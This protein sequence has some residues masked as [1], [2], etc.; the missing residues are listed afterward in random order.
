MENKNFSYSKNFFEIPN[1]EI[2]Y[3][4]GKLTKYCLIIPV[5]NEGKRIRRLIDKIN[6]KEISKLIDIVI[7]DGGSSDNSID[8]NYFRKNNIKGILIKN[9]LGGLSSQLR[10]GYFFAMKKKYKG[11]ITIDG[12]NKDCPS[13]IIN[14]IKKLES[15]YDFVQGSRFLK[16]GKHI[17]TPLIRYLAIRYLHAPLLSLF[18]GFHWTDTTQ[19]FRGYSDKLILSRRL[20]IFRNQFIN[21]ELLPYLNLS[22]PK[23]NFK[24]IEIPTKRVYPSKSLPSK[25]RGL[26]ANFKLFI[27]LIKTC[28]GYYSI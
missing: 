6:K 2:I 13:S 28:F 27:I 16:G 25:I 5:I 9:E 21:Y 4:D 15:G 17:N 3:W 20:S 26:K 23:K 18:S 10:I 19:G 1:F 7:V 22:A 24:C 11:V 12:N 14:F 8:E